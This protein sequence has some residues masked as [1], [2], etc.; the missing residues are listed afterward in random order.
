M[1]KETIRYYA[2]SI[3]FLAVAVTFY[4]QSTVSIGRFL[5]FFFCGFTCGVNI[6]LGLKATKKS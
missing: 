6:I 5:L 3:I 2:L 4:V 1:K